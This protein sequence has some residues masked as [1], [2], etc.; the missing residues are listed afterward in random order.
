MRDYAYFIMTASF[1]SHLTFPG[2][3]KKIRGKSPD[4]LKRSSD[5]SRR[6]SLVI[7]RMARYVS[8][9]ATAG[10]AAGHSGRKEAAIWFILIHTSPP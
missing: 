10:S 3:A 7:P 1:L 6:M 4:Y 2:K 5:F 8:T 9:N